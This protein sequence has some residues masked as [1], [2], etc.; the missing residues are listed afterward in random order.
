MPVPGCRQSRGA[1]AFQGWST[2][3]A[4][5]RT[6]GTPTARAFH[7][8]RR[9]ARAWDPPSHGVPPPLTCQGVPFSIRCKG[10]PSLL[11]S[12][13]IPGSSSRAAAAINTALDRPQSPARELP[14]LHL[15][16]GKDSKHIPLPGCPAC[17]AAAASIPCARPTPRAQPHARAEIPPPAPPLCLRLRVVCEDDAGLE[18]AAGAPLGLPKGSQVQRRP[19]GTPGRRRLVVLPRSPCQ[20][21]TSPAIARLAADVRRGPWYTVGQPQG[22]PW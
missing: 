14:S 2:Q 20:Q 3:S 13:G 22:R 11:R 18:G 12:K 4:L 5:W 6:R 21:P 8:S 19:S 1:F 9:M 7:G 17:T 15:L 10:I 16:T